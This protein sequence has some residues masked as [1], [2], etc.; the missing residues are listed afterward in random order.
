MNI[1]LENEINGLNIED[2]NY[3]EFDGRT[4]FYEKNIL[5]IKKKI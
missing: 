3:F 2:Y 1:Y 4:Y 5:Y